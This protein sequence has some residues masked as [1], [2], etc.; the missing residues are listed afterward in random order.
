MI[1]H[2]KLD[3]EA[4]DEAKTNIFRKFIAKLILIMRFGRPDA[5]PTVAFLS[6]TVKAPDNDDWQ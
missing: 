2:S 4:L 1:V 6:T 3:T 5:K